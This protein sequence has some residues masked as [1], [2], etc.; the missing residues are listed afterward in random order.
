MNHYSFVTNQVD[1]IFFIPG[2]RLALIRYNKTVAAGLILMSLMRLALLYLKELLR[3]WVNSNHIY[4]YGLRHFSYRITCNGC[5]SMYQQKAHYVS[6]IVNAN[7]VAFLAWTLEKCYEIFHRWNRV[8][9][10]SK[11][12]S[13]QQNTGNNFSYFD[14]WLYSQERFELNWKVSLEMLITRL[15]SMYWNCYITEV[16]FLKL[17]YHSRYKPAGL[18]MTQIQLLIPLTDVLFILFAMIDIFNQVQIKR[19]D[20]IIACH[21]KFKLGQMTICFVGSSFCL[22]AYGKARG[23]S[24]FSILYELVFII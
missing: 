2:T 24:D 14:T 15:W 13:N 21:N 3:T 11:Q 22:I 7:K 1:S 5:F 4:S 18:Q 9:S 12:W 10:C 17:F 8:Q 19:N 20:G 16:K 6:E 23:S